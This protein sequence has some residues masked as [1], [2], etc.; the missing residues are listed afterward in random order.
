[1]MMA[2]A[3]RF[4]GRPAAERLLIVAR[5]VEDGRYLFAV[6]ADWPHPVLLSTVAPAAEAGLEAGIETLLYGRL[7]V[8]L[9]GAARV[10]PRRLPVRITHPAG[11]GAGL[12]WLRPVAVEVSGEPSAA[13]P[14]AAVAS[15]TLDEALS[16][17]TTDVERAALRLGGALFA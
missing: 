2:P 10:S 9:T 4:D 17:L 13:G 14:I 15:L 12:G 16:T 3:A 7:G 1:M 5:R 11:G 6:W 8:R